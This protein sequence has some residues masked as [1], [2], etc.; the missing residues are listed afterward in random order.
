[1]SERYTHQKVRVELRCE[2]CARLQ[3][4]APGRKCEDCYEIDT[5]IAKQKNIGGGEFEL[6]ESPSSRRCSL[7]H[8]RRPLPR[9]HFFFCHECHRGRS[10]TEYDVRFTSHLASFRGSSFRGKRSDR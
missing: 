1:M 2:A 5:W 7:D 9:G 3:S 6:Q 10:A 4:H 8:C